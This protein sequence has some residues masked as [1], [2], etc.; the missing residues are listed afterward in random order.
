MRNLLLLYGMLTCVRVLHSANAPGVR[1][2][3]V[4]GISICCNASPLAKA[5]LP[6]QRRFAGSF[7]VVTAE[8]HLKASLLMVS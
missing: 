3:R 8:Q 6:I 5:P 1:L 4:V 7:A 2:S